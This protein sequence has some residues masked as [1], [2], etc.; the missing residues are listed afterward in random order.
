MGLFD[1]FRRK[2]EPEQSP[3]PPAI[4]A[5]PAVP[6]MSGDHELCKIML[7]GNAEALAFQMRIAALQSALKDDQLSTLLAKGGEM[8]T[9]QLSELFRSRGDGAV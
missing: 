4:P 6:A 5:Q 2:Q 9:V 1:R 3:P 8:A 7:G